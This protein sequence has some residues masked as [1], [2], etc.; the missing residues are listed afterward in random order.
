MNLGRWQI[1]WTG[2]WGWNLD[3]LGEASAGYLAIFDVWMWVG[4]V[5]IRRFSREESDD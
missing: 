5:E 4:P 2:A 1:Q 3:V